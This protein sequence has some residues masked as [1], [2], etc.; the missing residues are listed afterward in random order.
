MGYQ[1]W[2][3]NIKAKKE[4]SQA[5]IELSTKNHLADTSATQRGIELL[6]SPIHRLVLKMI[7]MVFIL[8][9]YEKNERKKAVSKHLNGFEPTPAEF[10]MILLNRLHPTEFWQA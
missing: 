5:G 4:E 8:P 3:A 1:T 6:P 2:L 7:D 9:I 10:G